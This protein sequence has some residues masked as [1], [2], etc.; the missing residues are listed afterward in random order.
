VNDQ[1]RT[2][3]AAITAG[4]KRYIPSEFG[5]VNTNP[6]AMAVSPVFREKGEVQNYL[7][8]KES[9]GLTWTSFACGPW[10]TWGIQH[11]FLGINYRARKFK[12]WDDGNGY[13]STT[14]LEDAAAAVAVALKKP[15]ETANQL[16]LISNFATTQNE[17]FAGIEK[18]T[19]EKF[20]R[21]YVNSQE[22]IEEAHKKLAQ[23]IK[24]AAYATIET[25][26]VTGKYSGHLEKEGPLANELLGVP[27]RNLEDVLKEAVDAANVYFAQ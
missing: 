2:I 13:F 20:E 18:L 6:A 22:I 3:D 10:L 14:R 4:V 1:Y 17:L 7:K 27:K 12:V 9:T 8:S 26:F 21:E 23:G 19:G 11:S 24:E 16:L 15:E 5:L 25:A